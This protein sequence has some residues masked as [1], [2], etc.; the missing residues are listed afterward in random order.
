[1]K[2]VTGKR[3]CAVLEARGWQLKRINGSHNVYAKS[4][5]QARISVPL[6]AGKVLKHG[7]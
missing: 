5:I 1:M 6:H 2:S 7:L 4:G 3:F